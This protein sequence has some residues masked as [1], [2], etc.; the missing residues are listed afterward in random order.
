MLI[1]RRIGRLDSTDTHAHPHGHASHHNP[2]SPPP[3]PLPHHPQYSD[4]IYAPTSFNGYTSNPPSS[5]QSIQYLYR[6]EVLTNVEQ[7]RE[8]LT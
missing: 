7:L 2:A 1:G 5:Q 8:E 6:N 3:T 4:T